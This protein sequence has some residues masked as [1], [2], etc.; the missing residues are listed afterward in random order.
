MQMILVK[1]KRLI[2]TKRYRFTRKAET[3]MFTDSLDEAEVLESILNANGIKKSIN[4]TNPETGKREKLHVIESF[5]YDGLL[6][7]T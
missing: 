1:I 2:I 3:E 4:S 5:T 6:I 7:Y